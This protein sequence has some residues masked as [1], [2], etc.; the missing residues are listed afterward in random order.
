MLAVRVVAVMSTPTFVHVPDARAAGTL[1]FRPACNPT[2]WGACRTDD[3]SA[4]PRRD[5]AGCSRFP[6]RTTTPEPDEAKKDPQH[7]VATT[8]AFCELLGVLYLPSHT[9]EKGETSCETSITC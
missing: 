8:C 4:P 2:Q 1:R 3:A 6:R 7:H 5:V 9:A